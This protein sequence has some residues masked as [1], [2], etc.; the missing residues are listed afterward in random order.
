MLL[1]LQSN[2]VIQMGGTHG[3]PRPNNS[4]DPDLDM[5]CM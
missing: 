4:F 1:I 5:M 2:V 3:G